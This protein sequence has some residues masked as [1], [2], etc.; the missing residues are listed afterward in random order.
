LRA[1]EDLVDIRRGAP[2]PAKAQLAEN[3]SAA[4]DG[5]ETFF[6]FGREQKQ[7]DLAALN[8]I[9]HLVLVAAGINIRVPRERHSARVQ[10]L[11]L[12]RIAH[13]L[14]EAF[15]FESLLNHGSR[16][17]LIMALRPISAALLKADR[18]RL[19]ITTRVLLHLRAS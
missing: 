18:M 7:L 14:I 5:Q 8:E 16:F 13:L 2:N 4:V 6:T 9:D 10:C 1:F 17:R 15:R 11:V 3:I 12:Q 19:Q